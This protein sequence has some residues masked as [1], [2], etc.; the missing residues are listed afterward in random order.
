VEKV[1]AKKMDLTRIIFLEN[2]MYSHFPRSG[3][4]EGRYW[5]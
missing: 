5:R 1:N 4:A 3:Y 2:R